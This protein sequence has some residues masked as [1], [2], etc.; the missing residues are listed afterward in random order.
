[1]GKWILRY[2]FSNLID[3]EIKRDEDFRANLL[4]EKA[5]A[6]RTTP[7]SNIQIPET[8]LNG[9]KDASSGPTSGSTIKAT[10]GFHLPVST[11]GLAIGLATPGIPPSSAGHGSHHNP[12][13]TP[14]TE[15]GAQLE[16]TQTQRSST[17][18]KPDYFSSTPTTN[19]DGKPTTSTEGSTEGSNP[20]ALPQ[21]PSEETPTAQKKG[22]GM[23]G[24]KFNM[25][26]NMKKFGAQSSTPEAPKP[27]TVD[28]KSEDSDSRSTKTDEKVIEDNFYGAIQ[29]IRQGY[30]DQVGMG[31]TTVNTQ[32]SPSLP[33][34]TPVLKPPAS[35]TILI[36]ED[37]PDSGGVADLFE[38]KVG[39]LG[40]QADLIEKAAPV[41]L[42]DV[43]LRVRVYIFFHQVSTLM[44]ILT[45][46]VR[47]TKYPL[48]ILLKYPSSWSLI[49]TSFPAYHPTG[50]SPSSLPPTK[51]SATLTQLKATTVLT[52]TV[53]YAPARYYPTSP[54][55][56]NQRLR[57]KRKSRAL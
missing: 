40:Q 2:L 27:A 55:E 20:E 7:P 30:E 22:K 43:L 34:E 48:K 51:S 36:Q 12:L 21:S 39:S 6:N 25:S 13:L 3:E 54:R 11:P 16:K 44:N 17:Q 18:E 19:G 24:K 42:A 52:P 37:R 33:N 5:N 46:C 4:K 28:E 23:F 53:C 45:K 8:N 1:M 41:W 14:T 38:G 29:K 56:S 49:K 35:T 50:T 26:F 10:N 9:W 47:R 31:A 57:K 32:I 15:E